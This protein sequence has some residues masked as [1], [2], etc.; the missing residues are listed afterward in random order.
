MQMTPE[1]YADSGRL[2][3][4]VA[5]LP[6]AQL[7]PEALRI[8]SSDEQVRGWGLA[9]R[10]GGVFWVQD[11]SLEGKP[12]AEVRQAEIVRTGVE[13]QIEGMPIGAYTILPYDTWQGAYLDPFDVVCAEP[14]AI[15]LPDFKADMAFKVRRR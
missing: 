3:Q 15:A 8:V 6:L 1:M 5:D 12:I 14:C 2:A 10:E 11:F 4:F 7:N 9:G 13:V